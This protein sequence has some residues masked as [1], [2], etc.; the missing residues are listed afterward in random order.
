[1]YLLGSD[2]VKKNVILML[3]VLLNFLIWPV[4]TR[5]EEEYKTLNFQETLKEESIEEAFTNYQENDEQITIYLFRGKGCGFCQKFLNFM[6]SITEE[7]GKYFKVK[8]FE[9]WNDSKNSK[10]LTEVSNFL[11]NPAGGVPYVI[12]GDKVFPGYASS[13]DEQIK[14]AITELYNTPKEE[15]YD[16]FTKMEEAKKAAEKQY[17]GNDNKNLIIAGI[18]IIV[19]WISITGCLIL[20]ANHKQYEKIYAKLEQMEQS[21]AQVIKLSKTSTT[22]KKKTRTSK[23]GQS[24]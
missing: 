7:Y 9:V 18:C 23:K 8:S 15:R 24:L 5:A 19:V 6:N 4:N 13:Y 17:C 12:I 21:N 10:L 20:R 1:M 14:S 3:V 2:F 16:V 22:P 11:E